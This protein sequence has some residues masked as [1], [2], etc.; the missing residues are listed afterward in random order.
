MKK[1]TT[2]LLLISLQC[3]S[4][5]HYPIK[6]MLEVNLHWWDMDK[7]FFP[8]KIPAL[9]A[10]NPSGIRIYYDADK[11]QDA[12]GNYGLN[13][14]YSGGWMPETSISEIKK[15]LPNLFVQVAYQRQSLPI[16]KDWLAHGINSHLNFQY[17]FNN[18]IDRLKPSSYCDMGHDLAVLTTRGGRDTSAANYPIITNPWPPYNELVKGGNYFNSIEGGN[19]WNAWWGGYN[20]TLTGSQLAAAWSTMYDSV[21]SIDASMLFTNGGI[22]SDKPDLFLESIAWWKQNRSDIPVDYFSYHS[23]PSAEGQYGWGT[24]G[25]LNPEIV[26]YQRAKDMVAAVGNL[27]PVV[28]GEW[29]YDVH[30][31]STQNAPAFGNYTAEQTRA[32]WSVRGLLKFDQAGIWRAQWYRAYQDYPNYIYDSAAEQFQTMALLRQYDDAVTIIKRTLVGDCFKQM[33]FFGDYIFDRAIRNDSL[34]ILVFKNGINY[35]YACWST[36][37]YIISNNRPEFTERKFNYLLNAAGTRYDLNEDSSGAMTSKPFYG[38]AVE[39]STKPFFV[40]ST[41]ILPVKDKP[42]PQPKPKPH[43]RQDFALFTISGQLLLKV[44]DKTQEEMEEY[45]RNSCLL[46][47]GVYVIRSKNSALKIIK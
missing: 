6:N 30:P 1:L 31:Q 42:K 5:Q 29:G 11:C 47:R 7:T 9:I 25:G 2:I 37:T 23:Y 22:A 24:F 19:E 41:T 43:E 28:I 3:F 33:M 4:Q 39:L 8:A 27:K 32:W 14:T 38:G 35:L 10:L 34:Q 15:S 16:Q 13:P 36:E 21:K 45:V 26:L 18:D 20:T 44:Q 12:N 46:L 17:K 40:V